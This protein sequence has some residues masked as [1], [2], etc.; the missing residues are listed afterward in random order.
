MLRVKRPRT[1]I[2]AAAA[3]VVATTL[4][5]PVA[6]GHAEPTTQ[7]TFNFDTGNAPVEIIFPAVQVPE[8]KYISVDGSDAPLVIDYVMALEVSWFDAIAPYHATAVGV[9]SNLGRR[10]R[11]EA[12]NRN[13]N[14]AILYSSYRILMNRIPQAA[15]DW[16]AMMTSVGLDPDDNQENT[17]TAA[18]IGNLAAKGMIAARLHDGLNRLGD[19]G[20]RKY[21]RQPFADYTGYKPVNTAY[22]LRNPSRWQ[23]NIVT[24]GTGV[25]TGIGVFSVQQFV[26]PQM[27]LAKPITFTDPSKFALGPQRSSNVRNLA[28]YK[29]QA[30]EV[31]AASAHLTDRQKMTSETFNDKFFGIGAW[32][33]YAAIAAGQLDLEGFVQYIASVEVATFDATVATWY[34]KVQYD[35]VRPFSAIRYLYGDKKVTAWGG[36][37]KGTVR[38]ITGNEWRSYLYTANHGEYPSASTALCQAYVQAARLFLGKDQIDLSYTWAAGSSSIEPGVTPKRDLTL[39]WSSWTEFA[40]DCGMSRFWSGVHFKDTVTQTAPWATQFGTLANDYIQRHVA[41]HRS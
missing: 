2:A 20:G 32:G 4:G 17:A 36:P 10:P 39:T 23:P 7:A 29:R 15:A 18:G 8:R 16:R 3:V 11:S 22:D 6:V 27:A 19:E 30:D 13:R 35:T 37:G 21:N 1:F 24:K 14:T 41:G 26:T 34:W 9:Y 28:A 38:D 25:T 40:N 12:T 33:G 5:G 31:L